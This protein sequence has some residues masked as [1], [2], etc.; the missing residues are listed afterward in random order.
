MR[1]NRS[2]RRRSGRAAASHVALALAK[3]KQLPHRVQKGR[4]RAQVQVGRAPL[5]RARGHHA[6]APLVRNRADA[7]EQHGRRERQRGGARQRR[8][9]AQ[10]AHA[11]IAV[12]QNALGVSQQL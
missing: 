3:R 10:G 12:Q 2:S 1:S 7:V 5:A 4:A 11:R 8:A 6:L 9:A